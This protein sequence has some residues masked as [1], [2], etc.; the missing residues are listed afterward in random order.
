MSPRDQQGWMNHKPIAPSVAVLIPDRVQFSAYYGGAL[1]RWTYEVYK[2]LEEDLRVTVFGFPTRKEDLYPL[3]YVSHRAGAYICE[4]IARVPLL[5][6]YQHRVWLQ[7]LA[8]HLRQFDVVHIHN[9]PACVGWL[10]TCGYRGRMVLHLQNDHLGHWT[11][12]MLENLASAV[13][14]VVVCSTYLREQF[15]RKSPP[16]AEKAR[17]IFNG[18]NTQLFYPREDLRAPKTIFFVGKFVPDKGVLQPAQAYREV[19]KAHPDARLVIGGSTGFGTHEGTP[20][21]RQVRELVESIRGDRGVQ[22]E[23]AGYLHHDKELPTWFQRAT[24]F[25]CPSLFQE[26]FGLVN[27]EAMACATPV[28]GTNRGGVP[29]VLA[30]TGA[31]LDP[32]DTLS[33][34]ASLS[35]LLSNPDER[36]R[37][38]Y[39]GYERCWKLFDWDVI[40]QAW[41]S[42]LRE[43]CGFD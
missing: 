17:V 5:R 6:R 41:L 10:R 31:L 1:A 38:G 30:D 24:I 13:D 43:A 16:L 29:E 11:P 23:F 25:S 9:R 39:A 21:V 42:L 3:P 2:R 20:Y 19:L 14:W 34:S 12:E 28:V 22:V 4:T 36:R 18:V 35:H 32:E 7:A 26:P 40:A 27:A 37:M 15:A 33:F 8:K